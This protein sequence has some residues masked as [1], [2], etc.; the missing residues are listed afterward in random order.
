MNTKSPK[1]PRPSR[2]PREVSRRILG[3]A[4]AA[5]LSGAVTCTFRTEDLYCEEAFAHLTTCCPELSD[6]PLDCYG[7]RQGCES[8]G[9][10]S[11]TEEE[12]ECVLDRDCDTLRSSGVC[13]R[14][15]P[16][17]PGEALCP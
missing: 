3:A 4:L 10:I 17:T 6:Y 2:P 14:A 5:L 12:S 11:L 15:A 8:V 16:L 13:E 9:Q 7:A 1:R